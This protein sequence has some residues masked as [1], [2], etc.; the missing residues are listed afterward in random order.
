YSEGIFVG[1]RWFDKEN[2]PVQYPFG[3]GL[4]YTQF[5]YSDLNIL[6][7][8]LPIK[9][10][11]NV[12][13]SGHIEG[14]EIVQLYISDPESDIEKPVRELK[15][16]DKIHLKPGESKKVIFELNEQSFSHYNVGQKEWVIDKGEFLI[17]VGT[18]SR[19][20]KLIKSV[21]P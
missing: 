18:S 11:V 14:A 21:K 2:I 16:F 5:D 3:Y 15:T 10:E 17:E 12:T 4:S 8:T 1:Y 19:D 20:L 7:S 13:N 9:V 6:N